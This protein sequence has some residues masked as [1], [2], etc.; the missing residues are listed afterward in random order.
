MPA[1]TEKDPVTVVMEAFTEFKASNDKLLAAKADGKAIGDLTAKVEKIN[2]ALD[3]FEPMNQQITLAGQQQKA[4]QEQLDTIEKTLNRPG[5][6]GGGDKG[7][8]EQNAIAAAFDRVMRKPS[9][10]R[11]PQDVQIVVKYMNTLTKGDD[12]AAGY[13]LAPPDMQREILK[14]IVEMSPIRSIATVRTIGVESYKRPK[15]TTAATATRVGETGTRSN[16]GD[17]AY[18]MLQIYAPELFARFEVSMQMLE[19]ADYDLSAELRMESAE[20]FAYKE[21]YEA[22]NGTGVG[23][24]QME[25]VLSNADIG[26]VVSGSASAITADGMIDLYHGVK[27]AY[28]RNGLFGLNRASMKAVRK[29]KDTTNQYLWVPGIANSAPNTILGAPYVEMP[30]LPDPGSNTY[31]VVYGDWRRGYTVVDR[32]GIMFQVDF[33]TG[34]DSGLVVFRARK[35]VGGGVVLAEA[36]K[37]MKCST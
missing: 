9:D 8:E 22:I 29:L 17:P 6:L 3:R 20:Q 10:R 2:D 15:R 31:P 34:A 25:G 11:D 23:T 1:P 24:N 16:T 30:D 5:A 32:T 19:D 37:K 4:M 12:T 7:K 13:L 28:T 35:R 18:G 26:E 33:T 36:L 27:T 14:N 21:G